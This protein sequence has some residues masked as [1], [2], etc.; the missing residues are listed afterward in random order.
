MDERVEE[1]LRRS[2]PEPGGEFVE[3]LERH[4]FP[5]PQRHSRRPLFAGA[6][7]AV[8]LAF[9]ALALSLAGVGPLGGSDHGV[10]AGS[11]CRF[12][13]VIRH[14]Q[15]PVVVPLATGQTTLELHERPVQRR[16]KRCS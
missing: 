9:T 13:T 2:R 10:Q 6:A 14:E 16:I 15:S 11:N 3:S 12:V 5:P 1:L 7:A 4:L 8:A